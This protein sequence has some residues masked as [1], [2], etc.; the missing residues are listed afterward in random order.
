MYSMYQ[1]HWHH[2]EACKKYGISEPT[3]HVMN[4]NLL[5]NKIPGDLYARSSLGSAVLVYLGKHSSNVVVHKHYI[6]K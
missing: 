2:Q 3:Q 5:F 6:L 1:Q 4:Q